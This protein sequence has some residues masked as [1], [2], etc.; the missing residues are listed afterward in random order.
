M[1]HKINTFAAAPQKGDALSNL[2]STPV[3][4]WDAVWLSSACS[5][6]KYHILICLLTAYC[7]KFGGTPQKSIGLPWI[8]SAVNE[9]RIWLKVYS[10]N[11][12]DTGNAANMHPEM[13]LTPPRIFR[14]VLWEDGLKARILGFSFILSMKYTFM[15]KA[16]TRLMQNL[17]AI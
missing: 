9:I 6:P 13:A 12:S 7:G 2:L 11:E 15:Q 8:Y 16:S 10:I 5:D 17:R 3:L 14:I 4:Q 1:T